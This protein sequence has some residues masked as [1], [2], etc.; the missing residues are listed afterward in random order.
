MT[1]S[2]VFLRVQATYRG[3]LG[4]EVGVFVAVDHLRRAGVLSASQ[5]ATYID[6][7]DWFIEHLPNPDFYADGNT[8]GAITWFKTPVPEAMQ[9]G[10][11]QLC[12]SLRA[13][14]VPFDVVRTS[15]PGAVVYEDAF[16][17]GVIPPERRD[18]TPLPND[19][20]QTPTTAGSKRA[21]AASAIRHVLFDA[22]GVLQLEP[23]V[24]WY[25]A[26]EPYVGDR[27]RELLHRAWKSEK[28][29]L[30][31][32]G[33]A[34]LPFLEAILGEFG[35]TAP[36]EQVYADVWL[37][38]ER[39]PASFEIIEALRRNGYGVHLGTNQ[40]R[41]RG[42]HMRTALGYD[43]VF[44]V[45]CYSYDLGV[46]KPDTRFFVEASRR[47]CASPASI[48]FVDDTLANVEAARTA[49][50]TAVH[51]AVGDGHGALLDRLARH[52]VDGRHTAAST[53]T[54]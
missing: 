32:A 51:W 13:H 16:Q 37:R 31:G 14:G 48:L 27:A 17:V 39:V 1:A 45:S 19:L 50:M 26:M 23:D 46:V 40:E 28:P 18:P 4:V 44:D 12:A 2:Q 7:E 25:G 41:E 6:V 20:V 22:D 33:G 10:V 9:E 35:V 52:G 21:V 47:I 42:E 29:L 36:T 38:I 15:E 8:I 54:S 11:D 49:G 34:Y 43:A 30:A 24:G 5:E 3:R 53:S